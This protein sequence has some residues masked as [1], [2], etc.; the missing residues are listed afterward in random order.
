MQEIG[1]CLLRFGLR[2]IRAKSLVEPQTQKL[3]NRKP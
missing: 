2:G 1:D 3:G